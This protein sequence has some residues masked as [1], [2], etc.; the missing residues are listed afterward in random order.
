MTGTVNEPTV[1]KGACPHDCP[2]TCAM[3]TTVENGQ[4]TNVRGNP[5]YPFTQGTLCGK[6]DKYLERVYSPERVL[7]PLKRIGAKGSRQFERISWD[8]ALDEIE[9]RFK[10]IIANYGSQAIL[11]CNYLGQQGILNGI[12]SG[13]AFFNRLGASITERTLCNSGT[14]SAYFMTFGPSVGTDPENFFHS[15]YIILWACNAIST[16]LH[17]WP[18]I[19]KA[20][21]QG[22]KLVVIDPFRTRTAKQADWHIQVRPGTDGALALGMMHVIVQRNLVD[23]DYVEKYTEGYAELKAR[24]AEFPPERVAEI[25]GV[26]VADIVTLACEYAS[27]Q[28]SVIRIGVA[29]E[30]QAGGG[31]AVRAITCLP[32]LVGAWRYLGG[33]FLQVTNWAFPLEW[34]AVQ[35][36][37]FI[38]PGT[39]VINQWQLG[40]ALTGELKLDPPIQALFV[41]NCNPLVMISEQDKIVTGLLREDLFTVVSEQFMTDTADF[42]D[43]VLP[44]TTQIEQFDLMYSW[45]QLY[46]TINLPAISPLGEA[47][48]NIALFRKLAGRMDFTDEHFKLTDEQLAQA[49]INWSSPALNGADFELIKQQGFIKLKVDPIPHAEGKFATPSGKC[50]FLSSKAL[51][52]NFVMPFLRHGYTEM[53]SGE[54]LDP[55]PNYTPPRASK[56]SNPEMAAQYPLNLISAKAHAF[57]NSCFANLPK[58]KKMEGAP[59]VFIHPEDAAERGIEQGQLVRVFNDRGSFEVIAHVGEEVM[60]GLV[61]ASLGH[62]RKLSHSYSSVNAVTSSTFADIGRA[63]TVSDV[64][65]EV[66]PVKS[67][68][69][70]EEFQL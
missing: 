23:T 5:D 54:V 31:Q 64:L 59:Q 28:P 67:L 33:G 13:D 63:A 26:A 48:P 4:A 36:P 29:L 17:L 42:A 56:Q 9:Q 45:G 65:V 52:G 11:P 27:I 34:N 12:A 3:L 40:S 32:A 47:I 8:A 15:K 24:A 61:V 58:H 20:R 60:P 25:T 57:I 16:N 49:A 62:W 41:Y 51:Q 2:D 44:A 6:V 43:I 38:P 66:I 30:R 50:E 68:I 10:A 69:D 46:L 14:R 19:N 21:R 37:D 1:I 55:L 22:A 39:R 70:T 35:R 53:Q 18:I 7:Y